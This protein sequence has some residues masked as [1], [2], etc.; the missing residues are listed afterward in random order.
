MSGINIQTIFD[1]IKNK[2]NFGLELLYK[3]YNKMM[4]AVA[5]SITKNEEDSKDVVQNIL[6][7][8]TTL[9]KD[10]FPKHGGKSWLY[11]VIKNEALNYIKKD[12]RVVYTDKLIDV[13]IVEE[14]ICELFDMENYYDMISTLSDKQK[15]VVTLKVLGDMSHKE[16]SKILNKPIGTIQWI[17][18]TSIKRLRLVFTAMSTLLFV[19]LGGIVYRISSI[20]VEEGSGISTSSVGEKTSL[21]TK[22]L[23]D[24]VCVCMLIIF[25]VLL[26]GTTLFYKNSDKIPTKHNI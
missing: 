21:I 14:N 20:K 3:E 5:F 1:L 17:Y 24:E 6:L 4:F 25:C 7:K 13:P 23:S 18:N 26:L 12:K 15:E 10:K 19:I 9:D 16:I 8:L 11:S 22:I 2:E